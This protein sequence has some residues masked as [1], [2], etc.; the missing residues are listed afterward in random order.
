MMRSLWESLKNNEYDIKS[1]NNENNVIKV[2]EKDSDKKKINERNKRNMMV[3]SMSM[4]EICR[5]DAK[6]NDIPEA[7]STINSIEYVDEASNKGKTKY[8]LELKIGINDDN[9]EM[10]A[11]EETTNDTTISIAMSN[12]VIRRKGMNYTKLIG[13]NCDVKRRWNRSKA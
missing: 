8:D 11:S 1:T 13:Y 4:D 10:E 2:Y 3:S 6:L 7:N 5:D 12:S 9:N